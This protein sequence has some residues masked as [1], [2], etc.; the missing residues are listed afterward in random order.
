[1]IHGW[2][3]IYLL[4]TIEPV[5]ALVNRFLGLPQRKHQK[6]GHKSSF[7]LTWRFVIP[8]IDAFF[9]LFLHKC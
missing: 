7:L 9:A 4:L 8:Y 1:M 2:T 5:G 6:E 3:R